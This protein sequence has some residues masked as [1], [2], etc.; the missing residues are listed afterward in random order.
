MQEDRQAPLV[1]GGL[2]LH[3]EEA[4]LSHSYTKPFRTVEEQTQI[5]E[6]RGLTFSDKDAAAR[7]LLKENYYTVVDGYKDAFDSR[8]ESILLEGMNVSRSDL[9]ALGS[10]DD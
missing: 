9:L 7:F 2:S 3:D 1:P 10:S 5:L 4:A 8:L 6:S